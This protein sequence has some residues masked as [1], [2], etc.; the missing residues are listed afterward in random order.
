M[1]EAAPLERLRV[2][3]T[4]SHITGLMAVVISAYFLITHSNDLSIVAASIYF[5]LACT[6]DTLKSKIPN[7][8]NA[9]L[10]LA[11]IALSTLTLGLHGFLMSLAGLALGIGLLILPYLMGGMGAG[12]VKALGALGALIGP[13]D[14][15][16]VF[17]Y[18]GLYGGGLALLH[19]LFKTGFKNAFHKGWLSIRLLVLARDAHLLVPAKESSGKNSMRF[20]YATAIA[21]GYYSFQYWGAV[22]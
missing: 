10:L 2:E 12:D 19:Y 18:T 5:T 4:P 8:L 13:Y 17:V 11:G 16:Q 20:P 3:I 21:F 7:L 9:C 6:T 22:L 15:L 1:N 14:L